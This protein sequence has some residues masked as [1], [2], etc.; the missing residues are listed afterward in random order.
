MTR[1]EVARHL[2]AEEIARRY[3][4]CPH[5]R[6]KTHWQVLWLL[7]R[8]DEPLSPAQAARVVGLTPVWVRRLLRRWNAEGPG[9]LRDHRRANGGRDKL[10]EEQQAALSEALQG[11]PPDGGRWSGPKVAAYVADRWGVTACPQTGWRWLRRLGFSLLVPRPHNPGAATDEQ[12]RRWREDL[13]QRWAQLRD[14]HPDRVVELWAQDE[15]RLGLKPIARRVWALQGRRPS[16]DSRSRY[17]WLYAYGFAR[18]AT[19]QS[20]TLL[21]PRVNTELMGQALEE[22]GRWADPEGKK[23][24]VLLVDNAGWHVAKALRVPANVLLHRLPPCTPELQPVEPRWPLLRETLANRPLADL[25]ELRRRVEARGRWLAEN[26]KVVQ[27]A[28]GFHW[29][30]NLG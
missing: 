18:P 10:S 3:R 29:A 23:L 25:A 21:L 24:L 14:S 9:A 27:G 19:G 26:P 8:P 6:E 30:V 20:L 2:P 11:E 17:E 5:A 15:A 7:T 22:F 4:T 16:S 28:V 13:E 12:Q 1:L